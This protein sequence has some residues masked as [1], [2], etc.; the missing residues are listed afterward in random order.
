MNLL[1]KFLQRKPYKMIHQTARTASFPR[2]N[3]WDRTARFGLFRPLAAGD[4]KR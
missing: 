3:R 2:F 4:H 1:E